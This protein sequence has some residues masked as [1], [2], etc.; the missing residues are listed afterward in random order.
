MCPPG[1]RARSAEAFFHDADA[2][3]RAA[4]RTRTA[5]V[6][7]PATGG[8]SDE[9]KQLELAVDGPDAAVTR[10]ILFRFVIVGVG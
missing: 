10:I 4:A 5:T 8:R 6:Q 9:F 3:Q 2:G 1:E 7:G